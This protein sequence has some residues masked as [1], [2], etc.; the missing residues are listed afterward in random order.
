MRI[1]TVERL[2]FK[3]QTSYVPDLMHKL[4]QYIFPGKHCTPLYIV[5]HLNQLSNMYHFS[6]RE[7]RYYLGH[8]KFDV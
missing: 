3:R 7:Y 4:L 2:G 8:E 5:G 1:L 6:W